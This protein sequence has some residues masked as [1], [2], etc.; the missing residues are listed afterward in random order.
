MKT[1]TAEQ[2]RA[3]GKQLFMA[4]GAP[5]LDAVLVTTELVDASLMGLD[6]HG[7]TRFIHYL[8]EIR[9]GRI[10][11]GAPMTI[12]KETPATAIVDCGMN[13]GPVSALKMVD[14]V[15]TK[16]E[17]CQLALVISR[18]C[19]HVSRLGAYV[20]KIAERGL[21]GFGT[22]NSS[23][24]GHFVVPWGGRDGRLATNPLAYAAPSAGG[25]PVVLDMATSMIS[26]GKIRVLMHQGNPVPP[27]SILD[28]EGR[29]TSDPKAFYGPPRGTI[30]PLGGELG[31]KGFG[32][33]LLVELLSST[34]AGEPVTDKFTYMNGLALLAINPD[35]F[36]GKERFA[37]LVQALS[38]YVTSSRPAEG[39]QEVVMPG[40]YDF[41][42]REKRL[43]EG[44]GVTDETWRL[45]IEAADR[46]GLSIGEYGAGENP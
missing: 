13:F 21:F 6:S 28:G 43:R 23:K 12:V 15:C 46:F 11:P 31:Y 17:Q 26:E 16:A 44:I 1:L 33:S 10:K 37:E 9:M 45:L 35:A 14:I 25:H 34:L 19:H 30:L 24:H 5:E 32:L 4:A 18:H 2:W 42:T 22:A 27:G 38:Q 39:S 41:R 36:C 20:Q 7:I 40:E 3:L 8:D 29:P